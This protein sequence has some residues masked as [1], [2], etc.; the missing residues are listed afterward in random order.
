[1]TYAKKSVVKPDSNA[2]NGQNHKDKIVIFDWD[3]VESGFT[4]D[5]AGIRLT[6]NLVM[7]SGAYMVEVYGTLSTIDGGGKSEGDPDFKG[8]KQ[9]VKFSHP[10]SSVDLREFRSNWLNKNIGII[11]RKC[12]GD[13][14]DLYGSPCNPLQLQFDASNNKDANKSDFVFESVGRGPDIGY[15]EGT[16]S[17][18]TAVD[19]AS[20]ATSVAL[21]AGE[22]YQ[23]T[24]GSAAAV[25]ITTASNAT[26]GKVFTLLGSGG[27]YPS[28]ITSANDFLLKDG[29]TWTA[30]AGAQITFKTFKSGSSAY[31]FIEQSRS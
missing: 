6:G 2:G 11:D 29:T 27:T 7:K 25:V 24:D 21:E 4:R 28:T 1:M 12:S 5:A 30:L 16:I 10:G 9:T 18:E 23:L 14:K 17:L 15:Y 13:G 3:D 31:K 26:H 19:V 20:D 8:I 22:Q